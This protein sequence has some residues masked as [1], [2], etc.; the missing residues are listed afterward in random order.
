MREKMN[1]KSSTID[2]LKKRRRKQYNLQHVGGGVY[3]WPWTAVVSTK[4]VK[5]LVQIGLLMFLCILYFS[6][7][8]TLKW[9]SKGNEFRCYLFINGSPCE[10]AQIQK[11][12][13]KSDHS[14]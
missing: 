12:I 11:E 7:W 14:C 6:R 3:G 5:K 2:K 4:R 8:M 1:K 10:D 13:S 9:A